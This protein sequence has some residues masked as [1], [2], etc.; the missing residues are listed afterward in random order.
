MKRW[1]EGRLRWRR[2]PAKP[3]TNVRVVTPDGEVIPLEC[4]YIGWN[5]RCHMWEVPWTLP[6]IPSALIA[7]ELPPH[8]GITMSAWR[9]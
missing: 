2:P 8:T 9:R 1:L 3:P 6:T 7:D 5:G 4:V